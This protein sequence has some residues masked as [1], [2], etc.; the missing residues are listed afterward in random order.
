MRFWTVCALAAG[1]LLLFAFGCTAQEEK[2]F[3]QALMQGI[4]QE[5]VKGVKNATGGLLD[6]GGMVQKGECRFDSDCASVCEGNVFWKR[7]C[8]AQ[9]DKC[10]KTFETDCGAQATAFGEDSFP[11]LC[12]AS[13]CAD[14]TA[15][16]HARK[17][18]LVSQANDYTAAMQQTTELRQVAAKNC[19][20]ALADVTDKLIIDTALSF[21]RLPTGTTSIY[22]VTTRQTVNTLGKAASGGSGKMSA[23]EF[24]SLN[25]NAIK[26]LDSDY[27]L[28]SKKRDLVMAQAKLYEGK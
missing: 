7:G 25:C 12:T 13:G 1:L 17:E 2:E 22:S 23:E 14:D 8:N 16:I 28:L 10:V 21:G 9:T 3:N 6:L 24:I 15:A 4:Q 26:A 11:R 19:I 20:G 27:A 18:E 5:A